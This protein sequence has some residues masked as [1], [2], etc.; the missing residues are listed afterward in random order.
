MTDRSLPRARLS[1]ASWLVEG[2][3]TD[4]MP[5]VGT[6]ALVAK[7]IIEQ[8][9]V[10]DGIPERNL[11]TSVTTWMEPEAVEI[12]SEN[13]HRNFIDHAEYPETAEIEQRCIRMLADLYNAPGETTGPSSAPDG[14]SD[15]DGAGAGASVAPV[16]PSP[17][18]VPV[19]SPG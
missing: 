2:A 4:K 13:L 3:P 14:V 12:I 17:A 15:G 9:V 5:D 16:D 7:R 6:E 1:H 18:S 19:R 11:A 10:L 8:D